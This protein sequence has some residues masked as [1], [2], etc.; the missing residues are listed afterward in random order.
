MKELQLCCDSRGVQDHASV[1]SAGLK[2]PFWTDCNPGCTYGIASI[3]L[4]FE[5][6]QNS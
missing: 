6:N 2:R 3:L 1:L 4:Q 5:L